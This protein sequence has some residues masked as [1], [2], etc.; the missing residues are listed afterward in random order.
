M[1]FYFLM[2]K[3]VQSLQTERRCCSCVCFFHTACILNRMVLQA[4]LF[5]TGYQVS[6]LLFVNFTLF[7]HILVTTEYIS[8]NAQNSNTIFFFL[9]YNIICLKNITNIEKVMRPMQCKIT[10]FLYE[11]LD[12]IF[13]LVSN[14]CFLF[15]LCGSS[16]AE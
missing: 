7:G 13:C 1:S 6:R 12:G 5:G 9:K 11:R 16:K 8:V 10:I 4:M 14:K 2:F 15:F 3:S